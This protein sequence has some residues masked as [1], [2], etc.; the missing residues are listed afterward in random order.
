MIKIL[1]NGR[2]IKP[3]EDLTQLALNVVLNTAIEYEFKEQ[4]NK[5][6]TKLKLN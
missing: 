6:L 3:T 4:E 2:Y 1:H 5:V